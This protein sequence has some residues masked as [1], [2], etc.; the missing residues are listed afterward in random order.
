MLHFPSHARGLPALLVNSC[1]S[2]LSCCRRCCTWR[3][4]WHASTLAPTFPTGGCDG[5]APGAGEVW[6]GVESASGSRS[7]RPC[8]RG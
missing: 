4:P 7:K 6:E 3:S 8:E 5:L 2:C 1:R